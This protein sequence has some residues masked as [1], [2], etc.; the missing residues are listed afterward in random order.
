[1]LKRLTLLRH[2]KSSWKDPALDDFER[3][4][5]ERGQR[6]APV[7]GR[8]LR[9]RGARPSL[10]LTSSA[11]RAR[12]TARRI[13]REIAYPVEFLQAEPDLYLAS[14]DTMLEILMQQPN[15]FNDMMVCGH[16]PGITELANRLTGAGIDNIPTCGIVSM[17]ADLPDWKALNNGVRLELAY[18]DYPKAPE[19]TQ[20]TKAQRV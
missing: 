19:L 2:A 6:D 15:D 17:Q 20:V 10:F 12:E 9:A 11:A 14:A 5:N 1:M 8:R 7:M 16:N 18:F 3:P 4:L 13:A